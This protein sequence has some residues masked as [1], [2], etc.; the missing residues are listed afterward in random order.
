MRLKW[1]QE[2]SRLFKAQPFCLSRDN[3]A[4]AT[5]RW[6]GT[7]KRRS[8]GRPQ[9]QQRQG[10]ALR[11]PLKGEARTKGFLT[12]KHRGLWL[13]EQMKSALK[14]IHMNS[15]VPLPAE[16]GWRRTPASTSEAGA[17]CNFQ[18]GTRPGS[19]TEVSCGRG[20]VWR[21]RFP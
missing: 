9:A 2:R 11:F 14:L 15:H 3:S 12:K 4:W 17:G 8:E 13:S 16:G 20:H 1:G 21:A 6:T 7:G 5:T 18:G 19:S 10:Q